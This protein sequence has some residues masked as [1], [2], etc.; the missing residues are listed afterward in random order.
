MEIKLNVKSRSEKA[1]QMHNG[2]WIPKSVIKLSGLKHPYY[3][4]DDWFLQNLISK[5]RGEDDEPMAVRKMAERQL[6]GIEPMVVK[7]RDIPE[8]IRKGH[9]AYWSG[10]GGNDLSHL[11]P[12]REDVEIGEYAH[13]I[14]D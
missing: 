1:Y 12:S 3:K 5:L 8:E 11:D 6:R 4:L 9:T 14:Y 2:T 10:F 13:G 7:W